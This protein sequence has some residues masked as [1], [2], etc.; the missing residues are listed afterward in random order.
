M[1]VSVAICTWNR[2]ALLDRTLASLQELAIPPGVEWEVLVVNNASSDD[3]DD[4]VA[5]RACRLPLR[6]LCESKRGLSHARNAAVQAARGDLILWTDD[7]VLVDPGWLGEHV[8]AARQWPAAAFFGGTIAPWFETPPPAWV[9]ANW[10]RVSDVYAAREFSG[11]GAEV[12]SH[13]M[14]YGANYAVRSDVQRRYPY[15]PN[16]GRIGA[17]LRAGEE[18]AV[19][20]RMLTDG[21]RGRIIPAAR[22]RHFI[23]QHRLTLDYACQWYFALGQM[24]A[25]Q[26]AAGAAARGMVLKTL[27]RTWLALNARYRQASYWVLRRCTTPEHWVWVATQANYIQGWLAP[28]AA[29][30]T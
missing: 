7:D 10:P 9:T 16:L 17:N 20:M 11:S 4:V 25:A 28:R 19:I 2:S 21:H 3:T 12:D 22:V 26:D 6:S 18:T 30:E 13:N 14:P 8:A 27:I 1:R 15:D 5:R 29:T 24:H 23:P